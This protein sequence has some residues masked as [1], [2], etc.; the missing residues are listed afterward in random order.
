MPAGTPR[1]CHTLFAAAMNAGD[2]PGLLALYDAAA[3]LV[4]QPGEVAKGT[5]AIRAGLQQ[6]LAMRPAIRIETVHALESGDTALLRGRWVIDATGPDG[7][8]VRMTGNSTEV[9]R[10]QPDGTWQFL[11]DHPFGAD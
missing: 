11:I 10:R 6:F 8:P 4:P 9:V 7:K 1:E 5:D 2:L 3:I